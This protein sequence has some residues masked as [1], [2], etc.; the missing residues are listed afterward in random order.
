[1]YCSDSSAWRSCL[2]LSKC[3]P[4]QGGLAKNC[5]NLIHRKEVPYLELS[6]CYPL[7]GGHIYVLLR[8]FL[9]HG[10]RVYGCLNVI[11]WK[12]VMLRTV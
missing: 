5:L 3:H 8:C 4:L 7:E 1:M 12:E 6:K 10:G 9:V 2:W 11:H